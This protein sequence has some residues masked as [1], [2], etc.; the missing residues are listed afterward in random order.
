MFKTC[1]FS[2]ITKQMMHWYNETSNPMWK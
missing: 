1:G 2:Q